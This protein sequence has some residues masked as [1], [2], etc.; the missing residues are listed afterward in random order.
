MKPSDFLTLLAI[1]FA[2]LGVIPN[3]ERKVILLY[4]SPFHLRLMVVGIL[5]IHYLFSFEWLVAN[6]MPCLEFFRIDSFPPVEAYAYALS[7]LLILLPALKVQYGFFPKA[8]RTKLME[9]YEQ[10][11]ANNEIDLLTNYIRRF[12]IEDIK[13]YL[14]GRSTLPVENHF[15]HIGRKEKTERDKAFDKLTKPTRINYASA[16][17]DNLIKTDKFIKKVSFKHPTLL[18]ELFRVSAEVNIPAKEPIQNYLTEILIQ[19]H[20]EFIEEL[21]YVSGTLDSI[22]TFSKNHHIPILEGLLS[23]MKT[24]EDNELWQPFFD[25]IPVVLKTDYKERLFLQQKYD[26]QLEDQLWN[27]KVYITIV[28]FNYMIRE[29]IIQ[30]TD[31]PMMLH[32]FDDIIEL[33]I[34]RV[35][36]ED[37]NYKT[38]HSHPSFAHKIIYDIVNYM[39]EWLD[40]AIKLDNED[41]VIKVLDSFGEVIYHLTNASNNKISEELKSEHISDI[42]SKWFSYS[43]KENTECISTARSEIVKILLSPR[44]P[45]DST[46]ELPKD[47]KI[48]VKKARDKVDDYAYRNESKNGQIEEF[49]EKVLNKLA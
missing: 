10:L 38:T 41:R 12:H 48:I 37:N 26:F 9:W 8:N 32:F 49:E 6:W 24:A 25:K 35:I 45:N 30:K 7:I 14:K 1:S 15:S 36:L 29:S 17:Y 23:N 5:F 40:L 19:K 28:Y 11:L 34:E 20:P 47:Y 22:A 39:L 16:V 33:I 43:L 4:F 21:K 46:P 2:I 44:N 3:K 31:Y 18:P 42:I 13:T 27:Q